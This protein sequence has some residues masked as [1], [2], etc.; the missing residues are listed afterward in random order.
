[1]AAPAVFA[2]P[3]AGSSDLDFSVRTVVGAGAYGGSQA[4]EVLAALGGVGVSDHPGWYAAWRGLGDRVAKDAADAAAADR[5][6]TAASRYLRAANYLGAAVSAS[7]GLTDDAALTDA[8]HAHRAAWDAFVDHTSWRV[9]RV[10]IPF[11]QTPLPGYLFH[12]ADATRTGRTLVL[13][14]GSDESISQ[15]W[16]D[17]GTPALERGWSVLAFDGP[18]QQSMLFD[19]GVTFRR[20]W[21]SVLG[22]VLD[23]LVARSDVDAARI[24]VWGISQGGYWVPEALTAEHRFAAAVVDP[25]VVDVSASWTEKLPPPLLQLLQAGMLDQFDAYLKEGVQGDPETT[26]ILRFRARPYGA[27]DA[28]GTAYGAVMSY[29]LTAADAAAITTPLWISSPEGEQFWPGQ[30]EQLATWTAKVSTL[31]PFTAT[32]GAD[33]HCQPLARR[34]TAERAHDWL[35]AVVPA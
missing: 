27:P 13:V 18:G 16:T 5:R 34:L 25:G 9:E 31:V 3:F 32:E 23:A 17:L 8:F 14:N 30:S 35:D 29:R 11:E 10:A 4:G 21:G 6:V 22:P 1:V 19:H 15:L 28:W 24:A 7:A 26:R 20:D 33:L 2:A 12:P